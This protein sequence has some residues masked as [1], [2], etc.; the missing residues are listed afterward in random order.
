[1]AAADALLG[2]PRA[3]GVGLQH[4]RAVIASTT[5]TSASRMCSR[6]LSGAWPR[7]VSQ[8][9][10]RRGEIRSSWPCEMR[11]PTGSCASCGTAKL[12]TSKSRKLND[13]PVSNSCQLIACLR[14]RCRACAVARL[15]KTRRSGWRARPLRGGG[16][17]AVLV[18]EENGVDAV[19]ARARPGQHFAEP[20]RGK[21]RVDQH[22]RVVGLEE[23][24]VAGAAAA[25][26]AETQSHG[27]D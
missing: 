24:G 8:A 5:R 2:A 21:A 23:R 7:S 26:D 3:L 20:A 6:T 11:K 12:R 9:R 15:A 10:R 17:V 14:L 1:M 27:R 22:A 16:V 18:R 13:A 4:V 19:P 25:Q